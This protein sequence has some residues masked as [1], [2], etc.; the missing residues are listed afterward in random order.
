MSSVG[1]GDPMD[2]SLN[3]RTLNLHDIENA[4]SN[5]TA[6]LFWIGGTTGMALIGNTKLTL[7]RCKPAT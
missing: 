3:P 5:L 7:M 1:L 4:L 2:T 6:T